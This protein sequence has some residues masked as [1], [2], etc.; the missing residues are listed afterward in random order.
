MF[1]AAIRSAGGWNNNPTAS[2]FISA[3][4]QLLMRNM[5]E[6]GQGNCTPQDST[7]ILD[8]IED[9]CNIE[10]IPTG[11]SDIAIARRYDLELR[12]PVSNDHDYC[13][14][15][16]A[17]DI[18]EFKEAAISYMAGFTAK[19]V[20]KKIGCPECVAALTQSEKEM[21]FVSWKSNG[22]LTIPS[23]SVLK[24]CRETEK[25]VA[26]MLK[27]SSGNLPH[28]SGLLTA[29]STAVLA[30]CVGSSIF[31]SLGE[32]MFDS[33]ATNNH[34]SSLIKCCSQCYA[35]IRLNHLA[36]RK[37]ETLAGKKVRKQLSKLILF[38]HQ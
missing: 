1:F 3:Y 10:S 37:T 28:C 12:E 13:D 21:S 22:G 19:A 23:T 24:V 15:S 31:D 33:T 2:Q 34:I 5:I 38:N 7:K 35:H 36:K 6:G 8:N 9:Q 14:I 32:H 11:I 16:N 30:A 26:R 20:K 29:I 4:R 17:V 27:A 25:C 18:T